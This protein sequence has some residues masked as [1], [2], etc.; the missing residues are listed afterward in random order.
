M[1]ILA[2]NGSY[3]A[4]GT[5]ARL[6]A[7]AL[8][9]AASEGADTE[10]VLLVEKDVRYCTNCLTCYKDTTSQIAP[11]PID[12]DVRGIL[13]AIRDADGV[14]FT[15]PVHCGFVSGLMVA[16]LERAAWPLA[17]P[18]GEIMGLKG[19]PE[20]RLTDKARAVATI[21]SAGG[22]PAELRQYCDMG[23]P[24]LQ[25]MA[26][27]L[28]NGEPV[29]DMYAGAVFTKELEGDEHARSYFFRELTDAQLQQAHDLGATMV[30]ALKAGTVRGYDPM[31]FIQSLEQPDAGPTPS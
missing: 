3:R 23:T 16:F 4:K 10:A 28:C 12:D 26:A 30:R 14:L 6:T 11:C 5:T 7:K 8:E 15:S 29:G 2:I 13:E 18:T 21:V 27:G 1:K 24:W 31:R 25:E 17:K 20:P 9:G 22:M 19:M